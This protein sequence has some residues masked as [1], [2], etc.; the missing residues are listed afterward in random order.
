MRFI[1]GAALAATAVIASPAIAT[2][3]TVSG[4]Y[5]IPGTGTSGPASTYPIAFN[6]SGQVGTITAVTF[7][8]TGLTHTFSDDLDILLTGPTGQNVML[9]SDAGSSSNLNAVTYTF[10]QSAANSLADAG[11]NASG[12]YKP[13]NYSGSDG[14]NEAIPNVS[15]PYGSSLAIFNGLS[16]NGTW[17]LYINDDNGGDVGS[18]R[19]ATLSITTTGAV[20]EPATWA[21]MLVGF[22]MVGAVARRRKSAAKV[23]FA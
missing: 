1:F 7:T 12:T 21:M 6:V 3:F 4:P 23:T 13:S 15:G 20:P 9:M 10:S 16:A 5:T 22:G 2:D 17:N 11:V 8:L 14:A 18:L 19:S